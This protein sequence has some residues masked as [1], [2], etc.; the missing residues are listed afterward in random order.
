[1]PEDVLGHQMHDLALAVAAAV[2]AR[3]ELA[4]LISV[5]RG[6]VVAQRLDPHVDAVLGVAG[7]AD[8]P[9]R[10]TGLDAPGDGH[11]LQAALDA[12]EYL[13]APG[14]G[15]NAHAAGLAAVAFLDR[16]QQPLGELGLVKTE[17]IVLLGA[18]L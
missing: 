3:P 7:H 15:Q 1:K 18:L 16:L 8:A 5:H 6:E 12:A 14:F 2:R 17:E 9:V 11:A 13:V 10:V 4:A